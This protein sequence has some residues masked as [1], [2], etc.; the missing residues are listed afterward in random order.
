MKVTPRDGSALLWYNM[1]PD[2][3]ADEMSLHEGQPV[4]EGEKWGCN[5]W[6]WDPV[7]NF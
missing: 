3:N 6:V 7:A 5:L 2:G 4:G 1:L